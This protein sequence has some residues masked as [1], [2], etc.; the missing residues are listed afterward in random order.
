MRLSAERV[1]AMQAFCRD[2]TAPSNAASCK[3]HVRLFLTLGLSPLPASHRHAHSPASTTTDNRLPNELVNSKTSGSRSWMITST[4]ACRTFRPLPA[5]P[6][7]LNFGSFA[8]SLAVSFLQA[9]VFRSSWVSS[10][11][12]SMSMFTSR[13]SS[14][15][16][17]SSKRSCDIT[18]LSRTICCKTHF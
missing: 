12:V 14:A 9:G 15:T 3:R 6:S 16:C 10:L 5:E 11:A 7:L 17:R 1:P 2:H 8:V 4:F 18:F 13:I